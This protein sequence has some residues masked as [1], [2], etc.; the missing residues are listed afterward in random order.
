[1]AA[2]AA[3]HRAMSRSTLSPKELPMANTTSILNDLI[4]TSKDGEKGF[5]M[6]AENAKDPELKALFRQRA[7]DCARGATELQSIVSRMG[8]DPEK[9]GSVAGAVHRGW[10]NLKASMSTE[11]DLSILEEV[12][13]GEDVA[14]ASYK[15][16]LESEDLSPDVRAIVQK[17]YDGV[18]RNHDQ[19]RA[20]RDRYRNSTH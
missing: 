13:R 20:L 2:D 9:S 1:M 19:M 17:Q 18:L 7:E 12:E 16:A 4:E 15:K 6:S 8:G 3:A 11:D 14:K 5:L 10:V